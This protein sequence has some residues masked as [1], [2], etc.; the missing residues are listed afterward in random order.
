MK[1]YLRDKYKPKNLAKVKTGIKAFWKKLTPDA[2]AR[3]ID[4]LHKVLPLVIEEIVVQ[5]YI[6]IPNFVK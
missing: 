3:Y 6:N 2:C 1:C 5:Q 4:H